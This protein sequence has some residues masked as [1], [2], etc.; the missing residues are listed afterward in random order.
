MLTKLKFGLDTFILIIINDE[1][2][3]SGQRLAKK[4]LSTSGV[5]Y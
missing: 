1:N 3:V 2:I 4:W 5:A